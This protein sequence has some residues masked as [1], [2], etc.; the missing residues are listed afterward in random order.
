[1]QIHNCGDYCC[2]LRG[3]TNQCRFGY[4]FDVNDRA[5]FDEMTN[6]SVYIREAVDSYVDPHNP[7]LLK[8]TL[9]SM[10]IQVNYTGR[11]MYYLA[12]YM[13]KIDQSVE[14]EYGMEDVKT[15]LKAREMGAV[16]AACFLSGW[17]KH[18]SSRG[19]MYISLVFPGLDER[20]QLRR[21]LGNLE[22]ND[23]NIFSA[24]H[25]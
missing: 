24:T 25:V 9:V 4:P 20:R 3:R 11:V 15:H 16:D 10:D 13:S 2:S 18:R 1:M 19:K 5:Y 8:L 21:N 23:T 14:L 12:K 17:N 6:R 7:Y 22:E